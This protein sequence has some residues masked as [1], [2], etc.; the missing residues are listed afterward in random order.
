MC[1]AIAMDVSL[2]SVNV[3]LWGGGNVL[4]RENCDYT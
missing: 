3:R 2:V 4:L 1:V